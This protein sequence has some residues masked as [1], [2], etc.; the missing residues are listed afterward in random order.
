MPTPTSGPNQPDKA[1]KGP[2]DGWLTRAHV[3]AEL[4]YRSI[5]PV[6]K[7]EGQ[8]LHPVRTA[9]GWLFDPV[10]VATL[11]ANRPLGGAPAPAP[12][13]T[14]P[15]ACFTCSTMAVSYARSSRSWRSLPRSFATSGTSGSPISKQV[16]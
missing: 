15:L 14:S 2:H 7:M 10:E 11:K 13:V 4:G 9:R 12:R 8:Q 5:F 1:S 6:R 3:A 16:Q